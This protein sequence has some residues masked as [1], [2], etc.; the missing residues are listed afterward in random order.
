MAQE[1]GVK[2]GRVSSDRQEKEG[3]SL[4]AQDK[5]LDLHA[6][7]NNIKIVAS[8][9]ESETAKKAGRKQ[10]NEMV[11]FLK[12]NKN[13]R[14]ILVE[15]TDRLYR[16]LKDYILLDEI[17]GLKIHFVKEGTI[18]SENSRS[19]D[20]FM[21]GIRVLMAKNYIDNL[22]EEIKKGLYEKAEQGFCPTKAPFGYKNLI[23]KDGKRVIVVDE[24]TAPFIK[25]AYELYA[26]G[27]Y[28][29]TSLAKTLAVY[30]FHP[31]QK[32]CTHK[33]VERILNNPF[34]I[35]MFKYKGNIYENGQHEPIITPE[36]Y[37][38]V[39]KRLRA[40]SQPKPQLNTFAYTGLI[41]CA[42]CG[43]SVTAERQKGAHN[44]G[45]YIYYHCTGRKGGDCRKNIREEVIEKTFEEE[46]IKNIDL[47]VEQ[48]E[49]I[50]EL[51]KD[52]RKKK[53]EFTDHTAE[54]LEKKIKL[55]R[56]RLDTLYTDRVDG[57]ISDELF[58]KKNNE[59]QEELENALTEYEIVNKYD[60]TFMASV[61]KVLEL[62]K[63][64]HIK[65]LQ[66]TP[67]EK[68]EMM[69]LLCSNLFLKGK[70]LIIPVN[71]PFD[72]LIEWQKSKKLETVGV[73]P[74]SKMDQSKLLRV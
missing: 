22:S 72:S 51:A 45:E 41:K 5:L 21:H 37:F 2:Y 4:P 64:A 27:R 48:I 54:Q 6:A 11:K 74:T 42:V 16:N 33:V 10:F 17:E 40:K 14:T 44:S 13:V 70:E 18:L 61:E 57:A 38:A 46:V 23:Q 34:Y 24:E 7:E 35:G 43:C 12:K 49:E 62:C 9:F 69:K 58:Y 67:K 31:N 53:S 73:E 15:K 65:Y 26:G 20:K 52:M 55:Y 47:S 66:R 8:F 50:V 19:Q 30:G 3:F 68:A 32:P 1:Q 25:Q 36:L 28:S 60:R 63:D 29:Y 71:P 59:W 56:K 39:Q